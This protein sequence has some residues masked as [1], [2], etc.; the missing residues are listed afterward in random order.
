MISQGLDEFNKIK[1]AQTLRTLRQVKLKTFQEC[2]LL[3][4]S[5][6]QQC[7]YSV[8]TECDEGFEGRIKIS[9]M[10]YM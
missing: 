4:Y 7:I 1:Y 9:L 10:T 2:S 3:T 5:D 8:N 6:I